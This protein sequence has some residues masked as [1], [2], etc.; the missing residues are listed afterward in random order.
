MIN[1]RIFLFATGLIV[2][3]VVSSSAESR[4]KVDAQV[5]TSMIVSVSGSR[6]I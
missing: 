4:T 3:L 2:L 5:R 6:S 1:S